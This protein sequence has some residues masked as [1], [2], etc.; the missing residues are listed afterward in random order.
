M[1][2]RSEKR[3]CVRLTAVYFLSAQLPGLMLFLYFFPGSEVEG[4]KVPK[5]FGLIKSLGNIMLNILTVVL[6]Y[7]TSVCSKR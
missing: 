1:K 7:I 3:T 5:G 2:D 6:L 4:P